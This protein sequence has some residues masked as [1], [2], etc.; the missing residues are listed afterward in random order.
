MILALMYE[1]GA[2]VSQDIPAS[3]KRVDRAAALSQRYA[4]MEAKGIGLQ[5][6]SNRIAVLSHRHGSAEQDASRRGRWHLFTGR[7]HS[8]AKTRGRKTMEP[9]T[10]DPP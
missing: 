3:L 1:H 4:E 5:G 6:E 2:G 7:M 8:S 10:L 9:L